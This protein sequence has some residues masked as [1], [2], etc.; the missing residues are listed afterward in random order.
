LSRAGPHANR[1][2][3][4]VKF[5][6][7]NWLDGA[8]AL[9]ALAL[10][11]NLSSAWGSPGD[12]L[13]AATMRIARFPLTQLVAVS[14]MH[15]TRPQGQGTEG[16]PTYTNACAAIRTMLPARALLAML[17][18]VEREFGRERGED[19]RNAARTL[20]LDLLTYADM[21]VDDDSHVPMLTLPHPR[22]H[23]RRFVLEPLA[24]I[25]PDLIVPGIN[26]SVRT[27]LARVPA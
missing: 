26:A 19:L 25:L 22:L 20:D 18:Q 8:P 12:T 23:E 24:E 15:I 17:L 9:C 27:L 5:A 21:V 2:D 1:Y 11:A 16:Q 6:R 3:Q 14:S 4:A 10:G 7:D 13:L